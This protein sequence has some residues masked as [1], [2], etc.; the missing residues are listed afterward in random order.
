MTRSGRCYTPEEL[1][2]KRKKAKEGEPVK[3]KVTDEEIKEFLKIIKKS[4]YSE[5]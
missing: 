2:P 1:E 3:P 4:E 5:E